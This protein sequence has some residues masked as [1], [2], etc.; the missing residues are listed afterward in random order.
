MRFAEW[1][2]F[3]CTSEVGKDLLL[4]VWYDVLGINRFT[5]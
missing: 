3:S 2:V 4:G 5:F 1:S